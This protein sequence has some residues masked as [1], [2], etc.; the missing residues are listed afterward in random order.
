M[1]PILS[2]HNITKAYGSKVALHET[3]LS[4]AENSITGLLGPNGAGKTTIIRMLMQITAPDSGSI[5]YRGRQLARTDLQKF[6][7]MPEERGL[8]KKMKVEEQLL[9]FA[10][11]NKI[12]KQKAQQIIN[13]WLNLFEIQDWR[14]RKV[15]ELSKGQQQKIQF[16]ITVLHD[17]EIL[18]LDEPFTGLDPVNAEIIK[19]EILKLAK[20][21]KTVILSTHRMENVEELCNHICLV[22]H[23]KTLLN[24]RTEDIRNQFDRQEYLI[25]LDGDFDHST[26]G[27][28]ELRVIGNHQFIIKADSIKVRLILESLLT[29]K[30]LNILKF[31]KLLPTIN[32]IFINL[33]SNSGK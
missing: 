24:G 25:K 23:G 4:I 16:I 5:S 8:Y 21:G 3:S 28:I 1:D 13:N 6:G 9:Y 12:H 10:S 22:N 11:L 7:Y 15:D 19:T 29:N 17:P 20:A 27:E 31:E 33:V 14:K 32:E 30:N 18:I 26:W 2:C